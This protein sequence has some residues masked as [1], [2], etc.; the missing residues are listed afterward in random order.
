MTI[1]YRLSQQG[2]DISQVV[3]P[4]VKSTWIEKT[5]SSMSLKEW[6]RIKGNN[7]HNSPTPTT[8]KSC[9]GI[10]DYLNHCLMLK[11]PSDT[12][13]EVTSDGRYRWELPAG[14]LGWDVQS[15]STWQWD[16]EHNPYKDK[17][18]IKFRLPI[19]MS[20]RKAK[21]VAPADPFYHNRQ[22][23]T[24]MP[25]IVDLNLL[26]KFG[27]EAT[28]AINTFFD[29]KNEQ[30]F[31]KAGEVMCY[32]LVLDGDTRLKLNDKLG[33]DVPPKNTFTGFYSTQRKIRDKNV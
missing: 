28:L 23:Y 14:V 4:C 7:S 1:Q 6:F 3:E 15:H 12:L 9:P 31:F 27:N 2:L 32:F 13:L 8:V 18:N 16:N 29:R 20:S 11:F 5:A 19:V 25:G 33:F 24:V 17:V 21:L 26:S 22:P 30:Y 10:R